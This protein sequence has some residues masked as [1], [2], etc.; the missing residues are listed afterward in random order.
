[1]KLSIGER[2]LSYNNI[3]LQLKGGMGATQ[4][5]LEE[6]NK[7]V[8]HVEDVRGTMNIGGVFKKD[9]NQFSFFM[10][11]QLGSRVVDCL[12]YFGPQPQYVHM[13][14]SSLILFTWVDSVVRGTE[15]HIFN[16]NGRYFGRV[17]N[18]IDPDTGKEYENL[19]P[20]LVSF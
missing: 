17:K 2:T 15:N 16:K 4:T 14:G 13:V 18:P 5:L 7:Q 10:K 1:V 3:T 9:D 11:P 12:G 19:I 20:H 8:L 6:K